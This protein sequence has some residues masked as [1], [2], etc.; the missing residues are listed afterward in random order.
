ME[1]YKL[2]SLESETVVL[3]MNKFKL[4]RAEVRDLISAKELL[5]FFGKEK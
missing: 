4:N 2:S 3:V 5:D 1:S